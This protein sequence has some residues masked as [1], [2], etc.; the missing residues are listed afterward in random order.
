[1]SSEDHIKYVI[2][3]V[4]G[5]IFVIAMALLGSASPS[6]IE[7]WEV[8]IVGAVFIG[9]CAFGVSFAVRPN[10]T[11][12]LF[13]GSR[14]EREDRDE[15][16]RARSVPRRGHH[17]ACEPFA[18]HTLTVGSKFVCAGCMGI[19]VGCIVSISLM[20]FVML[21]ATDWVSSRHT[22]LIAGGVLMVLAGLVEAWVP[23]DRPWRHL[24]ANVVFMMGCFIVTAGVLLSTGGWSYA[25]LGIV[26]CFLWL[27]TRVSIS[28]YHHSEAC[29]SCPNECKVYY[30]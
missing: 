19:L 9:A 18:G 11:S 22:D 25:V 29:R 17:P 27:E 12:G 26:I 13:P 21:K 6:T 20:A 14:D 28:Q 1:M 8:Y 15:G 23:S 3:S 4:I 24:L 2:L 5:M 10:W 7:P 16:P 30:L